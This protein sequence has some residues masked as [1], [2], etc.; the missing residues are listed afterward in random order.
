MEFTGRSNAAAFL[1]GIRYV[2]K[3]LRFAQAKA[4]TLTAKDLVEES[5]LQTERA[6]DRPVPFTKKSASL[7]WATGQNLKATVFIKDI[8]AGYLALEETGGTRRPKRRVLPVPAQTRLNSYGNM[9]RNHIRT[10]LA[11]PNVF[12]GEIN[13]KAG[14]WQRM[15][16]G[17]VKLLV[18]YA[19]QARYDK[20]FNWRR[21]MHA[22][23]RRRFPVRYAAELDRLFR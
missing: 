14:I 16:G 15:K 19:D 3:E 4:L 5:G 6:F 22:K 11:R 2:A 17:R 8:Q 10:L 1:R 7:I 9:P 13:G 20:L 12:Q 23:G 18:V 21:T